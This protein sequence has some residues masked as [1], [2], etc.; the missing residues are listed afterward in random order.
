LVFIIVRL[1]GF[2]PGSF[3]ARAVGVVWL[4]CTVAASL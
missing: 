2:G 1:P 4:T 3:I